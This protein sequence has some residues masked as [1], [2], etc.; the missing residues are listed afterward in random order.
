MADK[1]EVMT[2]K[3]VIKL[4]KEEEEEADQNDGKFRVSRVFSGA[5]WQNTSICQKIKKLGFFQT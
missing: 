4:E 2:E 1:T 3:A 5:S